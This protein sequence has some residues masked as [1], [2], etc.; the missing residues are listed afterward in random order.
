M[1]LLA[2][3]MAFRDEIVAGDDAIAPSSPGMEIYRDAYRGRLLAALESRFEQTRLWVG[4]GAFA[5]AGCHY[6]LTM[7]PKS[8]TLD[9]YGGSFPDMLGTLFP[10]DP[11]VAELAWL[12][13]HM[14]RA[15]AAPDTL[16]LDPAA[17]AAAGYSDGDWDR[18]T[19]AM[20]AGFA[21]RP[22]TTD[23]AELWSA[24]THG[25]EP[26]SVSRISEGHVLLVWRRSLSPRFRIVASDAWQ[27]ISA[28]R[29]GSPL[30]AV[31]DGIDAETLGSWLGTWLRD[32]LFASAS[33]GP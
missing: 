33:I 31:G 32:G 18:M 26:A 30:G 10:G 19:F 8:W 5:A 7:P 4:E 27:A 15:F 11:E 25:R 13:W 21:A 1:S 23:C 12:E 22:V 20:A 29:D 14:Q 6:I 24:L 9:D 28:L 17:L 16:E 3:Q 2:R